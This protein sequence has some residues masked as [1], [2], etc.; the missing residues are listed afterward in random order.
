MYLFGQG[1]YIPMGMTPKQMDHH[2][3]SQYS[4]ENITTA[5]GITKELLQGGATWENLDYVT[6]NH[7]YAFC[8]SIC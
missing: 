7:V 1:K 3:T 5:M 4:D 2:N 8:H 6:T